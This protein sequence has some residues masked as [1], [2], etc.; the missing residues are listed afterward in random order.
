MTDRQLEIVWGARAIGEAINRSQRQTHY[1]LEQGLVRSA[2]KVGST[3]TATRSG[4]RQE[5]GGESARN[6]DDAAQNKHARPGPK[7]S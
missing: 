1:L 3:W 6:P 4:L 5:F 2:R 7:E